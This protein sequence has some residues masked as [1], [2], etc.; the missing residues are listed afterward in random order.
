[1]KEARDVIIEF[2][3]LVND[4]AASDVPQNSIIKDKIVGR[5]ER[6]LISRVIV[7]DV[8]VD[9]L[10]RAIPYWIQKFTYLAFHA[11]HAFQGLA[12]I[13][14]IFIKGM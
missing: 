13:G 3:K 7:R 4:F 1:M 11:F 14:V 9:Q 8:T 6:G 5:I 12:R 2:V 10:Q